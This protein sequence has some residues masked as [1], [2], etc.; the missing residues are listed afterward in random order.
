MFLTYTDS[1]ISRVINLKLK[2]VFDFTD[3]TT[4]FTLH[5][6]S[7]IAYKVMVLSTGDV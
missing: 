5:D 4:I 6:V 7:V 3:R 1:F 2:L